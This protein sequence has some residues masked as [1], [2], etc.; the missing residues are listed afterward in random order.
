MEEQYISLMDVA[1]SFGLEAKYV[2]S[3]TKGFDDGDWGPEQ[4]GEKNQYNRAVLTMA[5]LEKITDIIHNKEAEGEIELKDISQPP[6]DYSAF[7]GDPEI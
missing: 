3:L 2:K 1:L 5:G 6:A 4:T 7:V